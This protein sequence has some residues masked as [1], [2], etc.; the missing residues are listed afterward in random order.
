MDQLL[1][2]VARQWLG[3]LRYSARLSH[4]NTGVDWIYLH[5]V[6]C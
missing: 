5:R 3:V 1:Y 6:F 2:G 4:G